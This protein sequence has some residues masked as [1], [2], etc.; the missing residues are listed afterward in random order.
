MFC[1][2]FL[3]SSCPPH[4]LSLISRSSVAHM[5]ARRL[6]AL[7]RDVLR[8]RRAGAHSLLD[9]RTS[10][11][12]ARIK[13]LRDSWME[14]PREEK[15]KRLVDE[16]REA[17]R[18]LLAEEKARWPQPPPPSPPSP[19]SPKP[20]IVPP[21]LPLVRATASRSAA[22]TLGEACCIDCKMKWMFVPTDQPFRCGLC[23]FQF[24]L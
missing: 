21:P 17:W 24:T 23:S 11:D 18:K 3:T 8:D 2:T 5:C 20:S 10:G 15:A 13:T 7:D 9:L 1:V 12:D 16:Q 22:A 14:L 6:F 4:Y 19:P